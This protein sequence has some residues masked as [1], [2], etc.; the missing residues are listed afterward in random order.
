MGS[1]LRVR[2]ADG[3]GYLNASYLGIIPAHAGSSPTFEQCWDE[4]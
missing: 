4:W 2:G 1:S 3:H